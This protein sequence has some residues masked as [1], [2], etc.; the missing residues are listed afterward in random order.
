M[1][2]RNTLLLFISIFCISCTPLAPKEQ[3]PI[4]VLTSPMP[5]NYTSITFE[6]NTESDTNIADHQT[7]NTIVSPAEKAWWELFNSSDLNAL[8][9]K[10]LANNFD[11]LS[12]WA[13]LRQSEASARKAFGNRLPS[14]NVNP[15]VEHKLNQSQDSNN[16]SA[17][18]NER[19]SYGLG[20]A[21]SYELDLW[22]RVASAQ[23]AEDFRLVAT[24]EDLYSATVS[25][26]A[27]IAETW[28]NL[29]G[30]RANFDIL[31]RQIEVNEELVTMQETRFSHGLSESLDVLQQRE[32]LASSEAEVP[33]LEQDA[34]SYRNQLSI[35]LGQL[36]GSLPTFNENAGLP[37]L[38]TIPEHGLPIQVLEMR[39]DVRAAWAR[40]EATRYD[41][42]EA[43]ANRFPKITFSAS[44]IFSSVSSSLL[45]SNWVTSFIGNLAFPLFDGGALSAEEERVRAVAEEALQNYIKTVANAI[46]E[47]NDALVADVAQQEKLRLLQKQFE[48]AEQA[49]DGTLQAYLEG[50]DTFLRY[51]TQLKNTQNLE[52]SIAKQHVTVI[53]AR[54]TLYRALGNLHFPQNEL[55]EAI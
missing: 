5:Q 51:V 35:L 29:L 50:T 16:V 28:V 22:G 20:F 4:G 42:S 7:I 24:R 43:R 12:A 52:R 15:S 13:R 1:I 8:E 27:L 48:L 32:I 41:I 21:A 47:V 25:V 14:L 53:N 23:K 37:S 33:Q 55:V 45:F 49:T 30:N 46:Q 36:P 31:K 39:P 54:I 9:E 34:M 38:N 19:T 11:I 3:L 17:T 6:A 2:I 40:L 18:S 44:H 26:S 10:A